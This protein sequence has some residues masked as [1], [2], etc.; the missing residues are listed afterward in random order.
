MNTKIKNKSVFIITTYISQPYHETFLKLSTKRIQLFHPDA[1]IIVLND[2]HDV[3]IGIE[4][5]ETLKIIN[6]K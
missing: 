3:S 5:T 4:Q 2:S 1:D 6:T